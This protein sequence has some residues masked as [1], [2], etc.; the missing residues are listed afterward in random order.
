MVSRSSFDRDGG[1][2]SADLEKLLQGRS[3]IVST[4]VPSLFSQTHT[5]ISVPVEG[6]N[7]S[8]TI[9][10]HNVGT[11]GT[12]SGI[13]TGNETLD[14]RFVIEG[15]E[16]NIAKLLSADVQ[17]ALMD[18]ETPGTCTITGERVIYVVPFTRLSATELE[19]ISDG[20][21][22][23]AERLESIGQGG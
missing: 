13:T 4:T 18:I 2:R 20:L 21:I 1:T 17:A 11:G 10:V 14:E 22:A 6:V 8:F 3:V 5:E 16:Q 15:S 19:T 7:A 23:I 9:S 12:N